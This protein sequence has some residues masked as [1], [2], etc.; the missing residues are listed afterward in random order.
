MGYRSKNLNSHD[1]RYLVFKKIPMQFMKFLCMAYEEIN[2]SSLLTLTPFFKEVRE[3]KMNSCSKQ[4]NAISHIM[5]A[6]EMVFDEQLIT[7]GL[8]LPRSLD[9]TN[10]NLSRV[11]LDN[12]IHLKNPHYLQELRHYL[13]RSCYFKMTSTVCHET[14]SRGLRPE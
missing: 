7:R 12:R 4:Y 14:V 10:G 13:K 1:D 3:E 11:T 6:L 9:L 5:T 2:A 8:W